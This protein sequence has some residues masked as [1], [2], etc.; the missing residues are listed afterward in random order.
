[1]INT[2]QVVASKIDASVARKSWNNRN[3]ETYLQMLA[4]AVAHIGNGAA[5]I[6]CNGDCGW[7]EALVFGGRIVALGEYSQTSSRTGLAGD[8]PLP[9]GTSNRTA[10]DEVLMAIVASGSV[11]ESPKYHETTIETFADC[12]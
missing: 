5:R 1:M 9:I 7:R 6:V 11:S 4:E 10:P 2:V 12:L 8:N 3:G